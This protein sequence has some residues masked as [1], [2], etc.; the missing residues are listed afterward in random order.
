MGEWTILER[1]LEAAV[2][3][4]STMIGS[5]SSYEAVDLGKQPGCGDMRWNIPGTEPVQGLAP[6][7]EVES[8][9]VL[10]ARVGRASVGAGDRILGRIWRLGL[11]WPGEQS[12]TIGWRRSL[13]QCWTLDLEK[14]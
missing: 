1:L 7:S 8:V 14:H 13:G 3:Q 12:P 4:H 9:L 2:Q 10:K 5:S 6:G 11:E